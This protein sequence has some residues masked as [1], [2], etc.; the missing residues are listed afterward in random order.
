VEN[1]LVNVQLLN[2]KITLMGDISRPGT[3]TIKNDRISILEAIGLGGDL[4]LTA[5]RKNILVIRDNN[6]VKESHRLD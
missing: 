5:N 2:F 3:Y 4:Q 6:G 1:P